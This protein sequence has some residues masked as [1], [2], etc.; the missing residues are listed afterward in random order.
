[1]HR[2]DRDM[3]AVFVDG[4][5]TRNTPLRRQAVADRMETGE[6]RFFNAG[7]AHENRNT[8]PGRFRIVT[9][10]FSSRQE[11]RSGYVLTL[12]Q[13]RQHHGVRR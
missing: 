3:I 6:A 1:M 10:E 7:Y 4:G 5:S 12:L 9:V 11:E 8:S 2:H 13:S